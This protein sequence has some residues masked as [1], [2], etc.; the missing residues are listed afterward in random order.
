MRFIL[1]FL[2]LASLGLAQVPP[3]STGTGDIVPYP[4]TSLWASQFNSIQTAATL[5]GA[6][7]KAALCG[8]VQTPG[9]A[10]KTLRN[11]HLMI[12]AVTKA[13]GTD[14]RIG[15]QPFSTT[16]GFTQPSGTWA[17][18]NTAFATVADGSITA[19]TWLRSGTVAGSLSVSQGDKWCIVV[20][21]ENYAGS[22]SFI[23]RSMN[24]K[25]NLAFLANTLSYNGSAWSVPLSLMLH[26]LEFDDG[27]Y[28][29]VGLGVPF[30]SIGF[31][32]AFNSGSTPDEIAL[33][34]TPTS[35][36]SAVGICSENPYSAAGGDFEYVLYDGTTALSTI[37]VDVDNLFTSSATAIYCA[38]FPSAQTLSIGTGYYVS[39][40]PT[41]ANNV[42]TLSYGAANSAYWAALAGGNNT[43]YASRTNA[44]AWT[45]DN[46]ARPAIWLLING[47]GATSGGGGGGGA[48]VVAQ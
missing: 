10:T 3:F 2:L 19:N 6:T 32:T 31:V 45:D 1:Y 18:G 46:T 28:G 48:Y 12:G 9:G 23:V 37:A 33:K 17:S 4:F 22:D 41:T 26:L 47:S 36:L 15:I 42:R 14:L 20:E 43:R 13:G 44:G 16:G 27:T 29:S 38:L 30:N 8:Y 34:V 35:A 40:K 25:G 7:L 11:I 21:P 5:N 24:Q 39:V